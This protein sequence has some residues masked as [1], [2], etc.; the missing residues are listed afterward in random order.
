LAKAIV[1]Q[2]VV[3]AA[4]R[5]KAS[6]NNFLE[7]A[8]VMAKRGV[9]VTPT[10]PGL[11]HPA[12]PGWNGSEG[13]WYAATTDL[14]QIEAWAKENPNFNCCCVSKNEGAFMLD[15]GDLAAS[16]RR[17][18]PDLPQTFTVKTPG[19]GLHIYFKHTAI[20][21]SLGNCNIV[22]VDGEGKTKK[23]LEVKGHHLACCAPGCT[24][25]D[26][27]EYVII[28]DAPLDRMPTDLWEWLVRE[29]EKVRPPAESKAGQA[30][31]FHP[32]FE[33]S[34]LHEHFEWEFASDDPFVQRDGA[35]YYTFLTCPVCDRELKP[36]E[37][38]S[39]KCCLIYGKYGISMN[40]VWCGESVRWPELMAAMQA[41]GIEQYPH[42]IYESDAPFE[43]KPGFAVEGAHQP[44]VNP[45]QVV[46]PEATE[47]TEV[48]RALHDD[49]AEEVKRAW[50]MAA[51]NLVEVR[52]GIGTIT[53]AEGRDKTYKKPRH[54]VDNDILVYV[55]TILKDVMG[56]KFFVDAYPY[57]FLPLENRVYKFHNSEDAYRILSRFGLLL[58]QHDYTLTEENIHHEILM[59]GT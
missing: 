53:D 17:G 2:P 11:R 44:N 47:L 58:T 52:N 54:I 46:F 57:I 31:K 50:K 43:S 20:S 25:D 36:E 33:R 37:I 12:M 27:G 49:R 19:G 29:A 40:C 5:I 6:V 16:K 45:L 21:R 7:T 48:L 1:A 42:F 9:A 39:R 18:M 13:E 28:D 26:G 34:D 35:E 8:T 56:A 41:K 15:I 4:T 38:R 14:K 51:E 3:G 10:Y 22:E 30:R 59:Y 23:I 24:R 32:D 55:R